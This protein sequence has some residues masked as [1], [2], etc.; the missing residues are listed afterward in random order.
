MAEEGVSLRQG[1]IQIGPATS[2]APRASMSGRC[3]HLGR[4]SMTLK[5][6]VFRGSPDRRAVKL[7]QLIQLIQPGNRLRGLPAC[8]D[9]AAARVRPIS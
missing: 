6:S 4:M 5:T 7:T 9:A 3:W 1:R 2:C 8:Q